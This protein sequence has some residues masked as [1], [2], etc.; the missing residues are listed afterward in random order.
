V[1]SRWA[2]TDAA[3]DRLDRAIS[4]LEGATPAKASATPDLFGGAELARARQDNAR[5][6]QASRQVEARLDAV[7]DR[8]QDL[9]ES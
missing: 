3:L 4:R 2:K 6:E 9:L 5:L 7:A 8:L 1:T